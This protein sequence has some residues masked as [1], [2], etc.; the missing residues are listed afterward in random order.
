MG[1][2]IITDKDVLHILKNRFQ[3]L[4]MDITYEDGAV[5]GRLQWNAT[6]GTLEYGLPGGNV[7]LQ[8]GQEQ[9]LKVTNKTG[10]TIE[11]GKAVYIDGA[12]GNRPTIALARADTPSTAVLVGMA[13]EN[14]DHNGSGYINVGGLVRGVDTSNISTGGIG[15][16]SETE[17]GELRPTPPASPNFTSVAGYCLFSSAEDG[18]FF[19]RALSAPR[20]QS[21]SDVDHSAPSADGQF[22]QWNAGTSRFELVNESA[23]LLVDGTRSMDAEIMIG[24]MTTTERDALVAVNGMIVYNETTNA[25]NFYENDAWVTK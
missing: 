17:A 21:L 22:Y 20:L 5:E 18:I 25:F 24:S 11:D 2:M 12:I 6:D 3:W 8:V 10:S 23:Y 19:V 15:F 4:Q 7:T 14:I 1:G 13:T 9:L 16:L